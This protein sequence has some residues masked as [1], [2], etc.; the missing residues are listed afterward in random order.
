MILNF[1]SF[2]LLDSGSFSQVKRTKDAT[3][4]YYEGSL[5]VSFGISRGVE[6]NFQLFK[7]LNKEKGC[8]EHFEGAELAPL[9]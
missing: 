8:Q 9:Y 1:S 7:I 2:I 3:G 6:C 5:E 4:F